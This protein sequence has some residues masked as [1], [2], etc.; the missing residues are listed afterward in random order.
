[1]KITGIVVGVAGLLLL[2]A[3]FA[4]RRHDVP[5]RPPAPHITVTTSPQALARMVGRRVRA[6]DAV[7]GA[8]VTASRRTVSVRAEGWETTTAVP[9]APDATTDAP[10]DTPTDTPTDAPRLADSVRADVESLLDDLPLADRPKVAVS[11]HTLGR[12]R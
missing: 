1:V 11:V 9:P 2:I 4:S 6:A 8:S 7:S 3:A 10:P 12:P 5:L